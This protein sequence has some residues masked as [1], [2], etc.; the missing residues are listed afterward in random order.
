MVF[1]LPYLFS[2]KC[3][4]NY[5]SLI[6]DINFDGPIYKNEKAYGYATY[7]HSGR[8]MDFSCQLQSKSQKSQENFLALMAVQSPSVSSAI[9][10]S[11]QLDFISSTSH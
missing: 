2:S 6:Y 8:K 5:Y 9:W 11:E 7:N 10:L 1:N 4:I 3:F